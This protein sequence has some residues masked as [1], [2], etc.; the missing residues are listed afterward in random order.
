MKTYLHFSVSGLFAGLATYRELWTEIPGTGYSAMGL[1]RV[2]V[3][4]L[5][6]AHYCP[7]TL[8]Q[9][10]LMLVSVLICGYAL[11]KKDRLSQP[12]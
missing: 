11:W 6:L 4:R 7:S 8:L 3:S 1:V 5:D 2:G 9:G 10:G 12:L